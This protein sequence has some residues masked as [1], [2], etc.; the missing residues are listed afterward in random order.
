VIREILGEMYKADDPEDQTEPRQRYLWA[1]HVLVL[2][3]ILSESTVIYGLYNIYSAQVASI[4]TYIITGIFSV[5]VLYLQLK[6]IMALI[7]DKRRRSSWQAILL[8]IG[9]WIVVNIT[10]ILSQ[11][12]DAAFVIWLMVVSAY[13]LYCATTIDNLD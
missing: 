7:S 5:F 13:I 12:S 6:I 9:L 10:T 1:T 11:M 3:I 8:N 4:L 2:D